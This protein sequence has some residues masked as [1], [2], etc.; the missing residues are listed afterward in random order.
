MKL[1]T[2]EDCRLEQLAAVMDVALSNADK[3]KAAF[4]KARLQVGLAVL[5]AKEVIAHGR[6]GTSNNP[7]GL[8]QHHEDKNVTV[9]DLSSA[10][11]FGKAEAGLV[12]W[13]KSRFPSRSYETISRYRKW[14]EA[15]IPVLIELR[16]QGQ[17][18]LEDV[19][20]I[21]VESLPQETQ[22]LLCD[23]IADKDKVPQPHKY[24][25]RKPLS[26]QEQL[27]AEDESAEALANDFLLAAHALLLMPETLTHLKRDKREEVLA[28]GIKINEAIRQLG[29]R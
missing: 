27:D 3:S 21:N 22:L 10:V 25:P 12:Q 13:I 20:E 7:L 1:A 28:A 24:H 4:D 11:K 2:Q 6:T 17:L 16:D 14:A 5:M 23:A 29:K 18:Q 8:N 26:P 19:R 15:K 9:T